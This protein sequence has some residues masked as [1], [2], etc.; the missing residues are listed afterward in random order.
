[1]QN[2]ARYLRVICGMW[3]REP[4]H[5]KGNTAE[6]PGRVLKPFGVGAAHNM[7]RTVTFVERFLVLWV[8]YDECF[9]YLQALIFVWREI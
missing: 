9:A 6:M 4:L 2:E 3:L 5:M 1:M 7:C 8:T